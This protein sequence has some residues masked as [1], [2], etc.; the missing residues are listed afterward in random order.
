M[1]EEIKKESLEI[2]QWLKFRKEKRKSPVYFIDIREKNLDLT[3]PEVQKVLNQK[4]KEIF[5]RLDLKNLKGPGVIKVHPG[6]PKNVTYLL[7]ELV[8][9][10]ISFL[11]EKG[12][13]CV[14]G[15]TTVI[16]SGPRGGENNPA[17]NV[18]SYMSVIDHN[19][20]S[21]KHTGVPFVILDRPVTSVP[22][23]IEF[24][25]EEVLHYV[26]SPGYYKYV[27]IA[28]GI[29]KAGVIFNNA[30]LTMHGLSP[31]ALCVKGLAMGGA[32]K[33]G[34]LQIHANLIVKINSELCKRCGTCAKNCP[35]RALKYD[36][37]SGQVHRT[38][39]PILIE[40]KCMGCGECLAVCPAKAIEMVHRQAIRWGKGADT[41]PRR[42]ADF[43]IN[44]MNGKWE[45]LVNIGHLYRVT[46]NCDC[47]SRP[48]KPIFSD[49]GL[50]VSRNPFALDMLAARLF[51]EQVKKEKVNYSLGN[52]ASVFEYVRDDYG[53]IVEP[54]VIKV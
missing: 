27:H 23:I 17:N 54:E 20:W 37:C 14:I 42:L 3:A 45:R 29:D 39:I 38:S 26:D 9:A 4:L 30:H 10:D 48:Q 7:P 51:E 15:D 21:K 52:Y 32:G 11:K 35:S 40:E 53:I 28:G 47:V 33:K 2:P 41:F 31:L 49:I 16:Y 44:M 19:R 36:N 43:L 12:I 50:I 34:K 18:S 24:N 1:E 22:G 5:Q 46:S 6:E 13:D 8:Q 25:E